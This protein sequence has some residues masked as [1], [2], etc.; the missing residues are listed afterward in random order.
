MSPTFH[1]VFDHNTK[2]KEKKSNPQKSW[3][4]A[5]RADADA[6]DRKK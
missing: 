2:K 3:R 4:Q 6:S 1:F 5:E